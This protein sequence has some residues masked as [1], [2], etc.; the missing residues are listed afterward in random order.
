HSTESLPCARLRA[1]IR[2]NLSVRCWGTHH[3]DRL[4][5]HLSL[6]VPFPCSADLSLHHLPSLLPAR[7]AGAGWVQRPSRLASLQ[8]STPR[9][10]L[11]AT[12]YRRRLALRT[13]APQLQ[14]SPGHVVRCGAGRRSSSLYRGFDRQD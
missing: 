6:R 14:T 13:F 1:A 9:I 11:V 2:L 8:V 4:V 10:L 7:F 3:A 12:R 5:R